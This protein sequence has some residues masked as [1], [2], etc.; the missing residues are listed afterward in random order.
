MDARYV[1]KEFI[2][3]MEELCLSTG[4]SKNN[5]GAWIRAYHF[6]APVYMMGLCVFAPQWLAGISIFNMLVTIAMFFALNG[7]WLTLLEKRLCDEDV[8][9]VDAWIEFFGDEISHKKRMQYT[10]I[11][12]AVCISIMLLVYRWR[13][14]RHTLSKNDPL[15]HL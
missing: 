14:C 1:R 7:C 3:R 10:Y 12:G 13:F 6:N 2:D 4:I 11:I 5:I 9:I 15:I 8:N